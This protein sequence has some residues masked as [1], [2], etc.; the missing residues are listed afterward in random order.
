MSFDFK[1][2]VT[3]QLQC[4]IRILKRSYENLT[5][6]WTVFANISVYKQICEKVQ[7][8]GLSQLD[9]MKVSTEKE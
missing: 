1:L 2:G 9:C 7:V 4:T 8:H 3:S 5:I 6:T